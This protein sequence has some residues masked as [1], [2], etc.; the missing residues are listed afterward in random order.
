MYYVNL[1]QQVGINVQLLPSLVRY[2]HC[3]WFLCYI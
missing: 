2:I 1:N 3:I